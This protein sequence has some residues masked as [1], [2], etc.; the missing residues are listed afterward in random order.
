MGNGV[1]SHVPLR[2]PL[3][4]KYEILLVD[5]VHGKVIILQSI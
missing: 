3:K 4:F 1:E 5:S 2:P